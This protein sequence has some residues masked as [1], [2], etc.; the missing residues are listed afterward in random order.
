M[1]GSFHFYEAG[2][3]PSFTEVKV[4]QYHTEVCPSAQPWAVDESTPAHRGREELL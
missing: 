2:T 4:T 1:H 3:F